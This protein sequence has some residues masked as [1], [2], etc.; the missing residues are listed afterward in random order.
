VRNQEKMMNSRQLFDALIASSKVEDVEKALRAYKQNPGVAEIPFGG[1]PNNRGAIE[2][3]ADAARSAIERVTNAHDALLELEHFKHGGKPDCRSPREAADAWLNVPKKDG[4]SG[5]TPKERQDLAQNCIVRL[6]PGEGWQ[7]RILTILDRGIGIEPTRMKDTILSLNESNKIQK[8]Y[9]AGTYGQGGSS[10]L[11]F[12]KYVFIASRAPTASNKIAFT[13]VRYE[14]LPADE[15]KTGRYVYLVDG[16]D[17]LA[18]DAKK[19]DLEHGT[20]IR[21]F[22]YDLTN[23]TASIGPK[24]LYGALQR[25][26]F[27]PVAP[28][29]LENQVAG[30]NRTIKGSRNA[31]N[32]ALDQGD[33][34]ARGPDLDYHLPIF[35]VSLGDYGDIGIEYWVPSRPAAKNGKKPTSKPSRS[36]V[37]DAKPIILSHNGQNQGELSGRL[38]K[39]DADLPFLQTQGRLIVHV[40]CDRL[41]PAAKRLL[42]AS[43]REQSREG[44]V[45][46]L[47]QEEVVNLLKSD[48]ELRRLNEEAREQSLKEKDDAAEKQMQR[49]VAK[50]LRIVGPAFIDLGGSK[51]EG[52]EGQAKRRGPRGKPQPIEP[53]E[54]PTYIKIL[55]DKDDEITFFGGQ[56]KYIRVE[57]DANADYHD[58]DDQK[59]SRINIVVGDDL[60][61]FGTSPL[62]GGR[63]RIGVQCKAEVAVGSKGGIRVELYRP[64]LS[65]LSDE[66]DYQI[67]EPPKPKED[68][69]QT[70]LPKF[71]LIPVEGPDDE[72]WQYVTDEMEDRDVRRH[73]SGTEMSGGVLYIYYS[74]M[75][76]RFTA[77]KRRVEQ[78][79]AA[80]SAS[81]QKRYEL[82]L[83]VHA[84]LVYDDEQNAKDDIGDEEAA[85]ELSRQERCRLASIAAMVAAQ[86][87]RTGVNTED[88]EEAA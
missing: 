45:L 76:P 24:S 49:Q 14:D 77:E 44:F 86:E 10:T 9:L 78:Q 12:S 56:R 40:N 65:T 19:G 27:D 68:D 16:S 63:M 82:W 75:F 46:S 20:M 15:Y 34:A 4:L 18:V 29:R 51:K 38:I 71:E 69:R 48:D 74:T 72:D 8:H 80:L 62:R 70:R 73:A 30:W 85:K 60:K 1:R 2:V 26:M 61:V 54:P 25:V 21:H 22:G 7:S 31:L 47:I 28:I 6:E 52:G 88:A 53:R 87:V 50:L 55:G 43:T 84:L 79:N 35:N 58:P 23:Y 3:A 37:D 41:S 17:V 11:A 39:K 32:G 81:Y 5:L 83:A 33:E 36:F 42:F 59:K 57:T 64:G 67:V 13:L 66:R